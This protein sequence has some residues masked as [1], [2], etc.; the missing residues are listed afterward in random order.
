MNF[1][2]NFVLVI[3]KKGGYTEIS[4]VYSYAKD[5][6]IYFEMIHEYQACTEV[7]L[8]WQEKGIRRT[9][10][11]NI[12]LLPCN[13]HFD[14]HKIKARLAGKSA[15]ELA[16]YGELFGESGEFGFAEVSHKF[17]QQHKLISKIGD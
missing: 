14:D 15:H 9:E 5:K 11:K 10:I 6:E 17:Y 8:P 2:A 12:L 7:F 16:R 3:W 1:L 4:P 13:E